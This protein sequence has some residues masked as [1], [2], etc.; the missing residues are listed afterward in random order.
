PRTSAKRAR[1]WPTPSRANTMTTRVHCR[2]WRRCGSSIARPGEIATRPAFAGF[3]YARDLEG[4]KTE[5]DGQTVRLTG[6]SR[7]AAHSETIVARVHCADRA[8]PAPHPSIP[9]RQ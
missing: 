3:F 1:H 6:E 8:R 4:F 5:A 9:A 2:K 7:R